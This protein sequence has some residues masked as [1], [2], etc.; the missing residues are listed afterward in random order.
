MET[1]K[2]GSSGILTISF[3][4]QDGNAITPDSATFNIYDEF[5]GTVRRSG[6]ISSLAS[7]ITFVTTDSD[8]AIIDQN[9]RYEVVAILIEFTYNSRYG[10]DTYKYKIENL[11]KVT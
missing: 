10:K 7:S 9:N 8:N 2:E 5:S 1:I 11:A 3:T 6:T 4:D